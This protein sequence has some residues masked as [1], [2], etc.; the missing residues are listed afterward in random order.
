MRCAN[1][2]WLAVAALVTLLCGCASGLAIRSPGDLRSPLA[3]RAAAGSAPFASRDTLR[4]LASRPS[5]REA[6]LPGG[7]EP[8]P[9]DQRRAIERVTLVVIGVVFLITML[10]L[11][12]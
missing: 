9:S 7:G 2:R 1:A 11:M 6:A 10:K 3:P 4:S 8:S 5:S 12:F